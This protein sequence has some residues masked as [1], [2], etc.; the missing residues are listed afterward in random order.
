MCN[1]NCVTFWNPL[2][3]KCL[4]Q[5]LIIE[6]N[7]GKTVFILKC[8]TSK[9]VNKTFSDWMPSWRADFNIL[10]SIFL[11][12]HWTSNINKYLLWE[13][14]CALWLI[15]KD[16][17]ID[18]DASLPYLYLWGHFPPELVGSILPSCGKQINASC[19]RWL[20]SALPFTFICWGSTTAGQPIQ[21]HCSWRL[22]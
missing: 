11:L 8:F 17:L 10:S 22:S 18:L 19:W 9:E 12:K 6:G 14:A 4:Q 7:L 20:P 5:P 3:D 2:L 15:S 21:V 13:K 1:C 16:D